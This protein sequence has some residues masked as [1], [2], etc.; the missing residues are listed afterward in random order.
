MSASSESA[1]DS[2]EAL[3]GELFVDVAVSGSATL[4]LGSSGSGVSC[5]SDVEAVGATSSAVVVPRVL[6]SAASFLGETLE[7][8]PSVDDVVV[9]VVVVV[10]GEGVFLGSA[11]LAGAFALLFGLLCTAGFAVRCVV[12]HS[13]DGCAA[14]H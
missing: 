9:A 13:P 11:F 6:L 3:T 12:V 14:R 8:G 2:A 4:A 5:L 10:E 1:V 7:L